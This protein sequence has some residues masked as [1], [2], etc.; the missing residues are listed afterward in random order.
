MLLTHL[1]R[2]DHLQGGDSLVGARRPLEKGFL[3]VVVPLRSDDAAISE[4]SQQLLLDG[5]E[6]VGPVDR[7]FNK[8]MSTD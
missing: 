8:A 3:W 4:S 6:S 7:K 5:G 2:D 1:E